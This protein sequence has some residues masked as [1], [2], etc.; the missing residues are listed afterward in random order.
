MSPRTE[1]LQPFSSICSHFFACLLS[2]QPPGEIFAGC[3]LLHFSPQYKLHTQ[4]KH[5]GISTPGAETTPSLLLQWCSWETHIYLGETSQLDVAFCLSLCLKKT[6]QNKPHKTTKK[7]LFWKSM[8]HIFSLGHIAFC[9]CWK[10]KEVTTT[11]IAGPRL[12]FFQKICCPQNIR[13][14]QLLY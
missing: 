12:L 8:L 14:M 1:T 3:L 2:C 10:I 5:P 4:L 9:T 13:D 11:A 6:Q 7:P